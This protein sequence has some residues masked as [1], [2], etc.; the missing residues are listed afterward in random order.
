MQFLPFANHESDFLRL[1]CNRHKN[2]LESP[3]TSA[4]GETKTD[5]KDPSKSIQNCFQTLK[6]M[7]T[8]IGLQQLVDI[9]D[10]KKLSTIIFVVE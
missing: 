9:I 8:T 3:D 4:M 2:S 7:Q 1:A 10:N 5:H 6:L